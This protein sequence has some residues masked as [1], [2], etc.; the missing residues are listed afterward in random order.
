MTDP[1]ISAPSVPVAEPSYLN[2][3]CPV[4][5]HAVLKPAPKQ[6]PSPQMILPGMTTTSGGVTTTG[7]EPAMPPEEQEYIGC[8]G[9]SCALFVKEGGR[10][11]LAL[12]PVAVA[13][14]VQLKMH[15]MGAP[16]VD[17]NTH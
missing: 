9:P 5:S 11:A 8:Q 17:P 3:F 10:C 7:V 15:E 6:A 1:K 12:I 16:A 4:L 14:L 2:Q 13:Q